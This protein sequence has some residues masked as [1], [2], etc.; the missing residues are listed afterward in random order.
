M[1]HAGILQLMGYLELECLATNIPSNVCCKA[2]IRLKKFFITVLSSDPFNK[3][4]YC[5]VKSFETIKAAYAKTGRAR[6]KSQKLFAVTLDIA[7]KSYASC[8]SLWRI[9]L[10]MEFV[11]S[12][13]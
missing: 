8:S 13:D 7:F 5:S 11:S 9:T 2:A 12:K 3:E 10:E 6:T 1:Y 4:R